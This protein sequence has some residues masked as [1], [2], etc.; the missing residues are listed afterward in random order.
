MKENGTYHHGQHRSQ[1]NVA[2]CCT[3]EAQATREYAILGT[4]VLLAGEASGP[5]EKDWTPNVWRGFDLVA[6][7]GGGGYGGAPSGLLDQFQLRLA[8]ED[9]GYVD[10]YVFSDARR[11]ILRYKVRF[12]NAPAAVIAAAVKEALRA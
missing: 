1:G 10:L 7:V 2:E 8:S 5:R 6:D 9:E 4:I 12:A 11:G 3:E